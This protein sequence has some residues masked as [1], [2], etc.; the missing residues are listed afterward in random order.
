MGASLHQHRRRWYAGVALAAGAL[1]LAACGGSNGG[2]AASHNAPVK[3][4][5]V[6]NG[7]TLSYILDEDVA[8]FNINFV[9]DNEFVLQEI[10]DQVWPSV[11]I[12]QPGLTE[13]VNKDLV[14]SAAVTKTSPQT[15]VYNI[16]PKATWS[17][18]TPISAADFIYNW[19]AQSGNPKYKD[20]GGKAFEPAST[21]GYNQIK[22]MTASNGGKTVT[23]VMSK[24]FG[25]WQGM[26]SD[27]MPA[28]I[29]K[30]VGFNN[31]FQTF[32]PAVQVS[33]GP[34]EIQSYSKGSDLVEVPNPHYWGAAPHLSKLVFRILTDDNQAPPA[35]QNGEANM[36]NPAL[37]S[38]AFYD[39]VKAIPG[40]STSV[41]PGLEFQHMDFNEANPYLSSD[42]VRQAIAYGTNR[43][44]MMTRI[45]DPLVPNSQPLNGR[46]YMATQPQFS[47][48]SNGLGAFDPSKAKQLLAS[49]NMT[50]GSDGYF[51]PN[52]GP[53]KGQD[54]TLTMSTTSG[55]PVRQQ[56]EQLF[57]ADM[58][59]VGIK[60]AI[61]N[62][63]ADTFF[64]KIL[65]GGQFDIGEF[66]WVLSPYASG[67]QAIYCSYTNKAVCGGNYDHYANKQV[68][69]LFNKA[70][71]TV[72]PT[73]ATSLY[74]QVDKILWQ[75]MVTLPL[76]QQPVLY[77]WS[78]KFGNIIPNTSSVGIPWNAQNWGV[79][80]S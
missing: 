66:A 9:N 6:Q 75:D 24:P 22:T 42:K 53:D 17:D 70:V 54:L 28:H 12:T 76:F 40:F 43:P 48:Q 68:D 37:A 4:G 58:K 61:K 34:F 2:G 50:M 65:P 78:S 13:S 39:Q 35:I 71:V 23:V 77:G 38:T 8:G 46:I 72:D 19:Q 79:L 10:M 55:V 63:D 29:A 21:A 15:I 32:G 57:Q 14:T 3:T 7:G 25:D 62:Y 1:V 49:D 73:Q 45:V 41:K 47:D 16:N 64:G 36:V 33:G 11:F 30:K 80:A 51:H 26:F 31:G 44:E 69:K 60:I 59:T 18:G 5:A 20:L 74:N 52:F 27:L 56:I 67:N